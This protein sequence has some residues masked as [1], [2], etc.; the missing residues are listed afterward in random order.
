MSKKQDKKIE[1]SSNPVPP[2]LHHQSLQFKG[3]LPPPNII[4]G[5]EEVCPGSADRIIAM[6]ERQSEH[7]MKLE[8]K[9]VSSNIRKE[10]IGQWMG[11]LIALTAIIGGVIVILNNKSAE[12]LSMIIT[13]LTSLVGVFIYGRHAQAKERKEK[14]LQ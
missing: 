4:K 5:Y 14:N 11:F 2:Q 12:G 10:S 13:A 3:P 6:A 8:V 1:S 9:V 7:R